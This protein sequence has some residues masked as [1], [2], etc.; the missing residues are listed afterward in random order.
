MK[1]TS[2]FASAE[3]GSGVVEARAPRLLPLPVA[4]GSWP[5]GLD[6]TELSGHAFVRTIQRE[7]RRTDRSHSALSVVVIETSDGGEHTGLAVMRALTTMVRETDYLSLINT[8]VVAV[9]LTDTGEAGLHSFLNKLT[10]ARLPGS[11]TGA[12]YPDSGFD[13]FVT[14]RLCNAFRPLNG[15]PWV[16]ARAEK[17]GYMFK[18]VIDVAGAA[19]GLF[20]LLPLM[21]LV[22]LLIKLTSRGPVIFRQQRIGYGG[23]PFTFYKFRSMHV[24]ADDRIHRDFVVKLIKGEHHEVDQCPGEEGGAKFKLRTDPRVTGIGRFIRKTS[25]DELPQLL[26]V[27]KGDMSLVGPRPPLPYEAAN[28]DSWHL[29]RMLEV[30]PGITGLWQ[31]E[32]RSRVTFAEMVRMDLRYARDCSLMLDLQILAKTVRA[33]SRCEGA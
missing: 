27:L 30:R 1:L 4:A 32:G 23:R 31:V 24:H 11:F 26:N 16:G 2:V 12:T 13:Q 14:Q 22:A 7:K 20:A 8:H 28:Y 29:R 17:P 15:G 6:P 3:N 19:V 10:L 5:E 9:L 33:V 21:L 25:I 18:R